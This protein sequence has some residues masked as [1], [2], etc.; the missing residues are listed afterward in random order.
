MTGSA[1][2]YNWVYLTG[3][4]AQRAGAAASSADSATRLRRGA[5]GDP[6]LRHM[7]CAQ[8]PLRPRHELVAA[9][10]HRQPRH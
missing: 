7:R 3:A 5:T 9:I 8:P 10:S 2:G 6:A 1:P 4:A